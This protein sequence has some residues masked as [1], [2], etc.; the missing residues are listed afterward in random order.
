M[1]L[2]DPEALDAPRSR[3]PFKDAVKLALSVLVSFA[4]SPS[5]RFEPGLADAIKGL[6]RIDEE[7]ANGV[8]LL[9]AGGAILTARTIELRGDLEIEK[10][11]VTALLRERDELCA[12]VAELEG[13][14]EG[15]PPVDVPK[16]ELGGEA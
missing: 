10:A 6:R 14:L 3:T 11:K 5:S 4:A 12:R 15:V 2:R 7:T 9:G 1:P 8:V 13:W 16:A